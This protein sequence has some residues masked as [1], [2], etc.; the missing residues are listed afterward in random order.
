MLHTVFDWLKSSKDQ[1]ELFIQGLLFAATLIL[2]RVGWRQAKAADAQA[3]AAA[4]QV[5][6]A[7]EQVQTA[8][9]Q[10]NMS[11][12]E[13]FFNYSAADAASRPNAA[14]CSRAKL[15]SRVSW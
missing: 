13:M 15:W 11:V 9:T 4:A 10:L 14:C 5:A 6:A 3:K 7:N 1:P 12:K 8:R 2:I